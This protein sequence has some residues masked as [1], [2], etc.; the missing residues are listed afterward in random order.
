M[1]K[2]SKEKPYLALKYYNH[3]HQCF[4]EWTQEEL[5][6]FSHFNRKLSEMTWEML[7]QQGGKKKPKTGLGCTILDSSAVDHLPKTP[8]LKKVSPDVTWM[9]MRVTEKARIMGF[10]MS[11]VFFMVWLDR[12]HVALD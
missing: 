12:G 6:E 4:S 1:S 10:R 8:E 7:K 9:E 3:S 2:D 5:R 11:A